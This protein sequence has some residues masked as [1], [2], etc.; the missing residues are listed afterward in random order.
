MNKLH[1]FKDFFKSNANFDEFKNEASELIFTI[2]QNIDEVY[3]DENFDETKYLKIKNNLKLLKEKCLFVDL[4]NLSEMFYL[5][6]DYITHKLTAKETINIQEYQFI[7]LIKQHFNNVLNSLEDNIETEVGTPI[8]A[9]LEKLNITSD[10]NNQVSTRFIQT[11]HDLQMDDVDIDYFGVEH[12]KPQQE[13]LPEDN[14]VNEGLV[15]NIDMVEQTEDNPFAGLLDEDVDLSALENEHITETSFPVEQNNFTED[16]HLQNEDVEQENSIYN[17]DYDPYD[18]YEGDDE[19]QKEILKANDEAVATQQEAVQQPQIVYIEKPAVI[20]GQGAIVFDQE[21]NGFIINQTHFLSNA[22]WGTFCSNVDYN[23]RTLWNYNS[24]LFEELES[25]SDDLYFDPEIALTNIDNMIN[26]FENVGLLKT[27]SLLIKLK[28]FIRFLRENEIHYY[29]DVDNIVKKVL[30]AINNLVLSNSPEHK[31]EH[32]EH[33][34]LL[35]DEIHKD[36]ISQ[37]NRMA[38]N[39]M[40]KDVVKQVKSELEQDIKAIHNVLGHINDNFSNLEK[41]FSKFTFNVNQNLSKMINSDEQQ[42]D[43]INN[44]TELMIKNHRENEKAFAGVYKNL[45]TVLNKLLSW[46]A[47]QHDKKGFWDKVLK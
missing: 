15:E 29:Y 25:G 17:E 3:N 37:V 13:I 16:E 36:Y 45:E 21:R 24:T 8:F 43:T 2:Y 7:Q 9:I 26:D 27:T 4:N 44:L 35:I 14:I 41:V 10:R 31:Y 19:R 40:K 38:L 28:H 39:N 32:Y 22:Q 46:E 20:Y 6:E 5:M 12:L 47:Q 23:V 30:L 1:Q 34:F 11:L 33:I 18:G 42:T